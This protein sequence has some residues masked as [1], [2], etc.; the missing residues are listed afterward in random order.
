MLLSI[1][2]VFPNNS[3]RGGEKNRLLKS[4]PLTGFRYMVHSLEPRYV[5]PSRSFFTLKSIPN[6]YK[7][8]KLSVQESLNSAHRVAIT[9]DVWTS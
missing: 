7:E 1:F 5:I 2:F 8:T 3:S 4:P 6:L 9:C